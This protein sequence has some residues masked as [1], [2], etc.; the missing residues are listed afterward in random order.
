MK[1]LKQLIKQFSLK[2][3]KSQFNQTTKSIADTNLRHWI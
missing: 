1:Y 2:S 3:K